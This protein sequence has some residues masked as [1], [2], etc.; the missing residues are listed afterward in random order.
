MK[1]GHHDITETNPD[2]IDHRANTVFYAPDKHSIKCNKM[3]TE[4]KELYFG[5]GYWGG[6]AVTLHTCHYH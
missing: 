1:L 4:K 5:G 2:G 3:G 6:L